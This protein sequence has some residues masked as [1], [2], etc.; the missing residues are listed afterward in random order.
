MDSI[1]S[2]LTLGRWIVEDKQRFFEKE[3]LEGGTFRQAVHLLQM[4]LDQRL[5]QAQ[6][7]TLQDGHI[8]DLLELI[9]RGTLPSRTRFRELL[10][11]GEELNAFVN[12]QTSIEREFSQ[13]LAA[14][15]IEQPRGDSGFNDQISYHRDSSEK[16][17]FEVI[18]L[19]AGISGD[20]AL[21]NLAIQGFR[22]A[23]LGEALFL[24]RAFPN[25]LKKRPILVFH[26]PEKVEEPFIVF[27][28]YEG[29][30]NW[31][32]LRFRSM[33]TKW[34]IPSFLSIRGE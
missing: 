27:L 24:I 2:N 3:I 11:L 26:F 8:L 18:K 5:N 20:E 34:R 19:R 30:S 22:P 16:V 10:G 25:F 4:I 9:K 15:R 14:F 33:K 32:T 1:Q 28:G 29:T 12:Y 31:P 6:L 7:A 17:T 23:N 21:D 13:L